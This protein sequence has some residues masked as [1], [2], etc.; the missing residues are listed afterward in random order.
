MIA[1]IGVVKMAKLESGKEAL[2]AILE[3]KVVHFYSD[4]NTV[5]GLAQYLTVY[6][7]LNDGCKKFD[8]F[9]HATFETV[10]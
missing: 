7:I 8:A 6:E 9:L 3:G 10:D 1:L 4:C 5:V 2:K